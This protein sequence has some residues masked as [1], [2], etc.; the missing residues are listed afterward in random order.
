MARG[1]GNHGKL[2]DAAVHVRRAPNLQGGLQGA[3]GSSHPRPRSPYWECEADPAPWVRVGR[4]PPC[5]AR[6]YAYTLVD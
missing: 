6:L 5:V 4:R 2:K 3:W 1:G